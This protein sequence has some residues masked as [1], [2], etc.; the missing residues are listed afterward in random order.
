M[1]YLASMTLAYLLTSTSL[2]VIAQTDDNANDAALRQKL[3]TSEASRQKAPENIQVI[4]AD[5]SLALLTTVSGCDS[6]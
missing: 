5:P 4:D 1:K 3:E 2:Y 6:S